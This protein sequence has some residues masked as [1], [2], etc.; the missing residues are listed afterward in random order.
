MSPTLPCRAAL[1]RRS[2]LHGNNLTGGLPLGWAQPGSFNVL[3]MLTLSDN[4]YLGGT[5]PADWVSAQA[6]ALCLPAAAAAGVYA[7]SSKLGRSSQPP[8]LAPPATAGQLERCA[9]DAGEPEHLALGPHR[10]PAA[11]G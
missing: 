11:L 4:P 1:L 2:T 6:A 10:Q 9:T 3:K 5:L 8:A 7:V